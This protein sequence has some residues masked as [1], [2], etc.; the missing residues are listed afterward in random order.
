[1]LLLSFA[2]LGLGN[3]LIN[4][5]A[6]GVGHE[7]QKAIQRTVSSA[8]W[9]LGAVAFLLLCADVAV[10]PLLHPERIEIGDDV[11]VSWGCTIM[12]SDLHSVSAA[13]RLGNTY[14]TWFEGRQ[15]WDGVESR[16]IKI[17]NHS[18]IGMHSIVLK[19]VQIGEGA[20]VAA[21]SVVTRDVPAWTAV[22]G[23]PA[24]PIKEL[25]REF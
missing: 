10:Y 17:G 22:A 11:L 18:W 20:I 1:M 3:E 12:D 5:V 4:I 9:I 25:P 16:A 8:F 21:G 15:N 6:E 24:R 7:D 13:K 2:D 14:S 23:N 19:G